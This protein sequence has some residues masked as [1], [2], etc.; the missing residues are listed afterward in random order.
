MTVE[1]LYDG[2]PTKT[3]SLIFSWENDELVWVCVDIQWQS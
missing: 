2:L 3:E 1:K